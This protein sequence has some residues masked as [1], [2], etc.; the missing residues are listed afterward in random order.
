MQEEKLTDLQVAEIKKAFSICDKDGSGSIDLPELK[1]GFFFRPFRAFLV[2]VRST[3]FGGG[4]IVM[5]AILDEE[6]SEAELAQLMK[7]IDKDHSGTIEWEEFL[8]AMTNWYEL[9]AMFS[10]LFLISMYIY[11][12][13]FV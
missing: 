9:A 3:T 8:D 7:T 4:C 13:I 6:P 1:T 12:Y 2:I 11:I 10:L 5:T